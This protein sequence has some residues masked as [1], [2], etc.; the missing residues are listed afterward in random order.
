MTGHKRAKSG[1]ELDVDLDSSIEND[2]DVS[3][4][5]TDDLCRRFL[6]MIPKINSKLQKITKALKLH[7]EEIENLNQKVS[8]LD[9][10]N[11]NLQRENEYLYKKV[12]ERNLILVG[13]KED[14]KE[15]I[16]DNVRKLLEDKLTFTPDIQA[17]FRIGKKNPAKPRPVKIIFTHFNERQQVWERKKDLLH[18]YYINDDIHRKERERRGILITH[19]K[20]LSEKAKDVKTSF[21]KGEIY[22]DGTT[23]VLENGQVILKRKIVTSA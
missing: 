8:E 23:Y 12:N 22:A 20:K 11:A 10:T 18:P 14:D 13:M 16:L 4:L 6:P 19:A 7:T 9:S 3:S 15:V 5:T 21:K 1:S 17:A 2:E